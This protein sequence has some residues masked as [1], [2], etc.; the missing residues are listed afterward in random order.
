MLEFRLFKLFSFL[1][2]TIIEMLHCHSG[3][4]GHSR[5]VLGAEKRNDEH[6]VD[7]SILL[8]HRQ[9]R[10]RFCIENYQ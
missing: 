9:L 2:Q 4:S 1:A 3:V 7:S 5:V 10:T 8:V 6:I